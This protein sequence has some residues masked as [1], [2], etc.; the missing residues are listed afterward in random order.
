M[1][2]TGGPGPPGERFYW[3]GKETLAPL[4]AL[5]WNAKGVLAFVRDQVGLR[6]WA[7][8]NGQP[9]KW[10]SWST[11]CKALG[12]TRG[13][14][15]RALSELETHKLVK[16]IRSEKR[17]IPNQYEL[18]PFED[19]PIM[20]LVPKRTP[21]Q[22]RNGTDRQSHNGTL[23]LNRSKQTKQGQSYYGTN[24]EEDAYT[25]RARERLERSGEI[26]RRGESEAAW[27]ERI[28]KERG[29]QGKELLE[30]WQE[31]KRAG[32]HHAEPGDTFVGTSNVQDARA[33]GVP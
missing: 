11:I 27:Q 31:A 29:L 10:A 20:G 12:L 7:G 8:A 14:L 22:S 25:R 15:S 5:S 18:L 24:R 4:R 28:A 23:F 16:V 17:H 19:S 13:Q 21:P 9:F 3:I 33:S 1:A 2:A 32:P 6:D 26:P 30:A